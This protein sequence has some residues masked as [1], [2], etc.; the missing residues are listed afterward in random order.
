MQSHPLVVVGALAVLTG[1]AYLWGRFGGD[2]GDIASAP[3][4]VDQ[5]HRVTPKMLVSSSLR[6]E[7]PAPPFS[8]LGNDGR[9]YV[10]NDLLKSGPIV[11]VFIK[12]GCP[13]S[14]AADPLFVS[15]HSA[16]EGRVRF[17]GVINGDRRVASKWTEDH[18]TTFPIL[19][20]P[21]LAIIHAYGAE[22]SAY[23]ALIAP[24]GRIDKL[25]PGYSAEMLQELGRRMA[26]LAGQ[27]E[28]P[29]T[30]VDAPNELYSGCPF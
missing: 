8:A 10:L 18:G 14:D 21:G 20:D 26:G 2:S 13:C 4:I 29:F 6:S 24:D 17:F 23:V 9:T 12:E 25:W 5:K 1:G 3:I 16:Y 22:S 30:G 19:A 15:L 27:K 28:V 11:L 7:R